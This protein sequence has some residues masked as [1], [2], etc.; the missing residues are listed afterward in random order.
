MLYTNET[1]KK[2][3]KEMSWGTL[4][5]FNMGEN[6]RGRRE[7]VLPSNIKENEIGK[8]MHPELSIGLTKA[9][10][11]RIN[12]SRG[13]DGKVDLLLSSHGGYTRRGNGVMFMPAI[14]QHD[15]EVSAVGNGADGDAGRIGYWNCAVLSVP[16]DKDVTICVEFSG[17]GDNKMMYLV[18][19]GKVYDSD[20]EHFQDMCEHLGIDSPVP[21][22]QDEYGNVKLQND[23][24]KAVGEI[25]QPQQ[26]KSEEEKTTSL[27]KN[28]PELAKYLDTKSLPKDFQVELAAKEMEDCIR[29]SDKFWRGEKPDL[30]P[31]KKMNEICKEWKGE[32]LENDELGKQFGR[33]VARLDR[34]KKDKEFNAEG[35]RKNAPSIGSLIHNMKDTE[36]EKMVSA[37][38]KYVDA[39]T[40]FSEDQTVKRFARTMMTYQENPGLKLQQEYILSGDKDNF[41]ELKGKYRDFLSRL[42][43]MPTDEKLMVFNKNNAL[44]NHM[45]F[46]ENEFCEAVKRDASLIRFIPHEKQTEK[47]QLAAVQKSCFK[48]ILPNEP[49]TEKSALMFMKDPSEKVMM[50]AVKNDWY[51]IYDGRPLKS[52]SHVQFIEKPSDEIQ[53]WISRNAPLFAERVNNLKPEYLEAAFE[54]LND[55][56]GIRSRELCFNVLKRGDEELT[57]VVLDKYPEYFNKK[58]YISDINIQGLSMDTVNRMLE[59]GMRPTH[60]FYEAVKSEFPLK[61]IPDTLLAEM[62][63]NKAV[64]TEELISQK[65]FP[66]LVVK[67]EL[68]KAFES[69]YQLEDLLCNTS[70]MKPFITAEI[71]SEAVCEH[72]KN[73]KSMSSRSVGIA[74]DYIEGKKLNLELYE[75]VSLATVRESPENL[76]KINFDVLNRVGNEN[77]FYQELVNVLKDKDVTVNKEILNYFPEECRKELLGSEQIAP[78]YDFQSYNRN[79]GACITYSYVIDNAGEQIKPSR[80]EWDNTNHKYKGHTE[81][82][83]DGKRYW[84]KLPTDSVALKMTRDG[85]KGKYVFAFANFPDKVT[86][87]QVDEIKHIEDVLKEKYPEMTGSWTGQ[88]KEDEIIQ[89]KGELSMEQSEDL[90]TPEQEETAGFLQNDVQEKFDEADIEW[91]RHEEKQENQGGHDVEESLLPGIDRLIGKTEILLS[92]MKDLSDGAKDIQNALNKMKTNQEEQSKAV[93]KEMVA[94]DR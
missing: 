24:W 3:E 90:L 92:Q 7:I 45:N 22:R 63:K 52:A 72:L 74:L 51:E 16:P 46:S 58:T 56:I 76:S 64:S 79:S 89:G 91:K 87:A 88:I 60:E 75:K 44:I 6:G 48:L 70:E 29:S 36:I 47:I 49:G 12:T 61:K 54:N 2:T 65:H 18:H 14:Y 28:Q 86:Q 81:E 41:E 42:K 5:S 34:V 40:G 20:L 82:T 59:S 50:E 23:Y 4:T 33:F 10:K 13:N 69:S 17:S 15:I 35:L 62:V 93:V 32:I 80:F 26:F 43:D 9:G 21:L 1:I 53:D 37:L 66:D 85:Y 73:H 19:D 67:S 30:T 84:D 71:L 83:A 27:L 11:P 57:N 78:G 68:G 38:D 55:S 8:G 39:Q 94:K 77:K 25:S 31:L